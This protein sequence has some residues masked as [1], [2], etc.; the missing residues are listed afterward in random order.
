MLADCLLCPQCNSQLLNSNQTSLSFQCNNGHQLYQ[1]K[2]G[3]IDL[4]PHTS[5]KNLLHEQQHWDDVAQNGYKM[6]INH[7]TIFPNVYI[8]NRIWKE[9]C[10]IYKVII[11]KE[12]ENINRTISIVDIGCGSGS[13]I[14]YFSPIDFFEVEY[15]G[16]DVSLK[17]LEEAIKRKLPNNWKVLFLRA[18]ANEG[19]FKE[20]SLDIIFCSSALHH[21]QTNA[22]IKWISSSLKPGGLFILNEPSDKNPFAKIGRR[23]V[24]NLNTEGERPLVPSEVKQIAAH[25]NLELRYEKGKDFLVGP[26]WYLMGIFNLPKLI[27]LSFYYPLHFI[28]SFIRSPNLNYSFIQIYK[29]RVRGHEEEK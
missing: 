5:D 6:T 11:A 23:V 12:L 16:I 14:S 4:L 28:D 1:Y 3:I 8:G 26:I 29:K 22:I 2:R 27:S 15:I 21:M 19:I 24:H 7:K 20:N 18:S 9:C 17:L 10:N 13:A 25:N